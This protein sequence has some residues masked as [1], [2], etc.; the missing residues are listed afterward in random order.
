MKIIQI[1]IT[2][3]C[4]KKCSN[5]TRF[6][7]HHTEPF[8]MDFDT[9]KTAVD[10]L[11][12]FKGIVGIMGGESTIH[13]EFEKFVRYYRD[14]IGYDDFSTACYEPTS[15]FIKHILANA[16]NVNYSNHRGLWTSVTPK[17]Y[18]HFEL[19]QDTFGYQLVN[20]HS[21]PS[22]HETM[23]C[24]RKELGIPDEQWF[25]L[26]D[27]CWVQNLWSASI[28][29]KGAFFCEVAAAMDATLGGPG[30]WKVEPGWWKRTPED[31]KD[32]LHWCEMCS[33]AL[34]MPKR[35]ANEEVDDVS[36]IWHQKLIQIE[37]PKL[38]KG[39]VNEFNPSAY[40]PSEHEVI[41]EVTPYM[42]DEEQRIGAALKTLQ[43]QKIVSVAWLSGR[44]KDEEVTATLEQL[45]SIKRLDYVVSIKG[46]HRRLAEAAGV[47]FIHSASRKGAEI[48]AEIKERSRAK[49][50]ILLM[51]DCVPTEDS[52][53]MFQKCVFNPGVVYWR[54]AGK[55][56]RQGEE[57]GFYFFNVR[58]QALKDG[59]DLFNIQATYE[60]RK[61]VAISTEKL[62]RYRLNAAQTF[63]RR[64]IK[65]VYWA[66][67][68]VARK[69]T[70]TGVAASL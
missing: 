58:A 6:C 35:N 39:L 67:K 31:F 36:P 51:R 3:G 25:K 55:A 32:Q 69:L 41:N 9:F 61:I 63:Y 42:K 70:V 62:S 53:K 47:P 40:N 13:P 16:Y 2:N 14:T 52:L 28:T 68:R 21:N 11:K 48:Y 23:M 45:K 12:G 37:S 15:D 34:P 43:P 33:A 26:R 19:I 60:K 29:P 18:E 17:Y 22:M 54:S 4:P 1:E 27:N 10:S 57:P 65:R 66:Q 64:A 38:K 8:F 24:T 56:A 7:G 5:C 44:L 20:D 50:W 30:G 46:T 59:G 49:D